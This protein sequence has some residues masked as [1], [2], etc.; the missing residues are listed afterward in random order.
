MSENY[1]VCE[2]CN[3][4]DDRLL[5]KCERC[6]HK[7]CPHNTS[8]AN[9]SYC[10]HCM[11]DVNLTVTDIHRVVRRINP[12]T[13]KEIIIPIK[14]AKDY[15]LDG[16][17]WLY[18]AQ[19]IRDFASDPDGDYK[20]TK[21]IETYKALY[22]LMLSYREDTRLAKLDKARQQGLS[23]VRIPGANGSA[24]KV[25]S[26]TIHSP[27]AAAKKRVVAILKLTLGRDP[28]DAEI[29]T[30]MTAFGITI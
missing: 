8:D 19:K 3:S 9:I 17:D 22:N 29:K 25:L 12:S 7:F 18:A 30:G 14:I 21:M 20:F 11:M 26:S 5:K 28:T 27:E 13:G 6:G 2:D 23:Q 10:C 15:H 24:D 16:S 4:L 1:L